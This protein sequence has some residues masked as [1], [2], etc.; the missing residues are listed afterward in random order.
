MNEQC[1]F[2]GE[3]DCER[4]GKRVGELADDL[5]IPTSEPETSLVVCELV[6]IGS[7]ISSSDSNITFS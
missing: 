1:E 5:R 2:I 7:R 6:A 3:C 4:D